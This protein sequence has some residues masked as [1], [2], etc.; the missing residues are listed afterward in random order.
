MSHA[1]A[2][3]MW[4]GSNSMLP[5]APDH[6]DVAAVQVV[7]EVHVLGLAARAADDHHL[8]AVAGQRHRHRD[9]V[10]HAGGVGDDLRPARAEERLELLP[11]RRRRTGR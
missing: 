3:R 9:R 11:S 5:W 10:G 7:V 8:A 4:A 6:L 2:R 1:P